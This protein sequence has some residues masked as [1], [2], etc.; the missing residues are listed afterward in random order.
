MSNK[1]RLKREYGA[2]IQASKMSAMLL[3]KTPAQGMAHS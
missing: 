2:V 1:N 3:L